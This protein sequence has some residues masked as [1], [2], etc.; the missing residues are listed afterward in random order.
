MNQRMS[1][2]ALIFFHVHDYDGIFLVE[3]I[4]LNIK[5][6]RNVKYHT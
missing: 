1:G 6:V 2:I 3:G 4:K 5:N